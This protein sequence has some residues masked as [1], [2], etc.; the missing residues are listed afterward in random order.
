MLKN[1]ERTQA[2]VDTL[3]DRPR[4]T[5]VAASER[6][7]RG[8]ESAAE[9]L[10][11]KTHAAGEKIRERAESTSLGAHR[12]VA[13]AAR[14]VDRGYARATSDLSRAATTATDYVTANP[15]KALLL[16]ASAGFLLGL[17]VRGRREAA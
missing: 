4:D 9:L 16:V 1:S 8:V 15:G 6:T 17:L 11:E 14:A 10:V 13:E 2:G 7:E 12:S 5:V 3:I